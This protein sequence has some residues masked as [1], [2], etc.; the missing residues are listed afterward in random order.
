MPDENEPLPTIPGGY[1]PLPTF[2]GDY[3]LPK[4]PTLPP[5]DMSDSPLRKVKP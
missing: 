3:P 5:T 4:L 2:P 1:E